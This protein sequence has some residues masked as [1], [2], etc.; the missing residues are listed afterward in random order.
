MIDGYGR[1]I[2]YLR[3]AVTDR[4]NL[5]C[6]YCMPEEGINYI[7]RKELLSYEEMLRLVVL[8]ADQGVEKLRITGG[9]PFVRK[10][11]IYFLESVKKQSTIKSLN[12]TT[13]GTLCQPY[14]SA[15]EKL[16]FKSINL[17]LDT[18]DEDRFFQIARREG[19]RDVLN[20]LDAF[21]MMNTELK[22]NMVVMAD[23][24]VEDI[25]PMALL[26]KEKNLSVRFIEEM[27]F[28]GGS[29]RGKQ[30]TWNH[31]DIYSHL[32]KE[33]GSLD[34]VKS[35]HGSTATLYNL[36]D[37]KG[38]IGIIP[39]YSR[40]FCGLCNRL[41]ITAK[42]VLKTCLYDSGVFDI[43]GFMRNG[44]N[45]EDLLMA[46]RSALAHK[47]KDGYGAEEDRSGRKLMESMS[48]IGG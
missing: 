40:T 8:L 33:F 14:L 41:R 46:F 32:E 19:L 27:P 13:N 43:K 28:N 3:L 29:Q 2:N 48:T 5:R 26:A 23:S 37:F 21:S 4:C 47:A 35:K 42:G 22:I 38:Q 15:I 17:S 11:L 44:A 30:K 12:I 7:P 39:A 10:E 20:V 6:H 36:K 9:E 34:P 24:N 1:S 18:L 45:D 16:Q 31:I 25:I